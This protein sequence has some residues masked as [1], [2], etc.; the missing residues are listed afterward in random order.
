MTATLSPHAAPSIEGLERALEAAVAWADQ[1]ETRAA[2]QALVQV[3]GAGLAWMVLL[4]IQL[5]HEGLGVRSRQPHVQEGWAALEDAQ[6]ALDSSDAERLRL[7]RLQLRRVFQRH[8]NLIEADLR[9]DA[10]LAR[11][12]AASERDQ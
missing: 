5:E 1:D 10:V 11:A 12:G 6:R 3:L 9:R 4:D 2:L 7:A 8:P